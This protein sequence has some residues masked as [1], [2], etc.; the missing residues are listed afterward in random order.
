MKMFSL[1][2]IP[3]EKITLSEMFSMKLFNI[4][5]LL[6]SYSVTL[7]I[8]YHIKNRYVLFGI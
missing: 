1:T 4:Y 5:L 8:Y 2:V 6:I 7:A 3:H